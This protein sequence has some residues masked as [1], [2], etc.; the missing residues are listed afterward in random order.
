MKK[1]VGIIFLIYYNP[2]K[3]PYVSSGSSVLSLTYKNG[4][5]SAKAKL[6]F[7]DPGKDSPE[8]YLKLFLPREDSYH[9]R[10]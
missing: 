4:I 3:L 2:R 5:Y 10:Q 7:P 9:S 6:V 8:I 1:M